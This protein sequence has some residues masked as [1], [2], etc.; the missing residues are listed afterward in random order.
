MLLIGNLV[1][2]SAKNISIP[3]GLTAEASAADAAIHKKMFGSGRP[4]DLALRNTRLIISNEETNDI[5]KIIRSLEESSL[6]I[7]GVSQT[8]KNEAKE[9][10]W[11]LLGMLLDTIGAS[12]LGNILAG[13]GII[14][15][16]EG[17]VRAGQYF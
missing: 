7:K 4:S 14:R 2:P 9:Q 15:A 11:R 16:S 12:L 8:T 10:K 1:K 13:K 3:L 6:L 17:T 5:M